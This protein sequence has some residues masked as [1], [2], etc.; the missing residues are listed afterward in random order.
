MV[1]VTLSTVRSK[2]NDAEKP[3]LYL[4]S[5]TLQIVRFT[6]RRRRDRNVPCQ[7]FSPSGIFCS[8]SRMQKMP[9]SLFSAGPDLLQE[10][11][12]LKLIV[13]RTYPRRCVP[14]THDVAAK[15]RAA[16]H[17]AKPRP[18]EPAAKPR[19]ARRSRVMFA[20]ESSSSL[21][22]SR[23]VGRHY[24]VSCIKGCNRTSHF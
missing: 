21:R 19:A 9:K 11:T 22:F 7:S 13:V 3:K 16:K 18:C 24:K 12:I 8:R 23:K 5:T 15:P 6:R 10:R 1:R 17:A 2:V 4:A 14:A 20:A